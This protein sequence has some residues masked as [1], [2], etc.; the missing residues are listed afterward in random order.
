MKIQG[1][2]EIENYIKQ[3]SLKKKI[4]NK[5]IFKK[6]KNFGFFFSF[7]L[8]DYIYN[9]KNFY[10]YMKGIFAFVGHIKIVW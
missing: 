1:S 6:M 5:Q 9:F 10:N 4:T 3:K 8:N 7:F 2:G